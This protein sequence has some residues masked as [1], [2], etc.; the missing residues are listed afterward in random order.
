MHTSP[1]GQP[2]AVAA[3]AALAAV[4]VM[5]VGSASAL[6]MIPMVLNRLY[7]DFI[8]RPPA[9]RPDARGRCSAG[10]RRRSAPRRN[11]ITGRRSVTIRFGRVPHPT[12]VKDRC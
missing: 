10:R 11:R 2:W 8:L 1:D 5:V 6:A 12:G 7:G 3:L 9:G 4:A